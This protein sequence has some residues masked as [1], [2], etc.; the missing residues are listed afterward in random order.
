M[1]RA[2][3][4]PVIR[5]LRSLATRGELG[6]TDA[7]LLDRYVHQ[8]DE[9]AFE[10]LVWRHGT[11]VYGVCQRILGHRQDAEDAFQAA[12]LALVRK[13]GSLRKREALGGWLYR[14]ASRIARRSRAE[15]A[16]RI[17][18][19]R[20]S[21][22]PIYSSTN[23]E[24]A[25]GDFR[26][27]LDEELARL[28][29]RLRVPFVL[30]HLDGKTIAQAARELVCP[31]GTIKSRL[32]EA[33]GRLAERLTRRGITLSGAGLFAV[34]ASN[35]A[36]AVAP[37]PL[38]NSTV[39]AALYYAAGSSA[40]TGLVAPQAAALAE[41]VLR[42]MFMTK[43][44]ALA[45]LVLLVGIATAGFF[46]R[47]S[48]AP[49]AL[50]PAGLQK[51]PGDEK[52]QP[53]EARQRR[54]TK[55]AKNKDVSAVALAPDGKTLAVG[56]KDGAVQLLDVATG[57]ERFK[58]TRHLESVQS[59]AFS[60]DGKLLATDSASGNVI[61]F[62]TDTGKL[63]S[64]FKSSE[65]I[66]SLAFSPDGKLLATGTR[67]KSAFGKADKEAFVAVVD[68]ATRKGVAS[69]G[70]GGAVQ[71]L[72]YSHDGQRLVAVGSPVDPQFAERGMTQI[73]VLDVKAKTK[74]YGWLKGHEGARVWCVAFSPDD[75]LLATAGEDKNLIV[76]NLAT[77]GSTQLAGHT[78]AIWAVV[79]S[80][81]G[82]LLASAG[83]DN[84]VRLWD[85]SAKKQLAELKG[86]QDGLRAVHLS[87]DGGVLTV[88]SAQGEVTLWELAKKRDQ[89][90]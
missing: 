1:A 78:E 75:K 37:T 12:F 50:Q 23:D 14:V 11:M 3:L 52:P 84:T 70:Q 29:D 13:A 28:P 7:Q 16:R 6:A 15:T 10:L 55:V 66:S 38:V 43:L 42:A 77:G 65:L 17:A 79:F 27:V 86:H 40:D 36:L 48:A 53:E 26:S 20:Q 85:L 30:C 68:V 74:P 39:R 41:G 35:A 34:L 61:L 54:E 31:T 45:A 21:Q 90:K 57:K 47:S 24:V 22:G 8:R 67:Q 88:V 73:T 9:A 25:W 2:T 71:A 60:S 82:K 63:H 46:C 44:K 89:P 51:G 18:R 72:A 81:D 5:C 19:E 69:Y 80:R 59:L 87:A 33:R 56:L 62:E 64:Y 4:V 58:Q 83:D 49:A 32:A 76:W